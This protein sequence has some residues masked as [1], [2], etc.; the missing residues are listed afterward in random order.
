MFETEPPSFKKKHDAKP[1]PERI[2]HVKHQGKDH[3][4]VAIRYALGLDTVVIIG[5]FDG[6]FIDGGHDLGG[7]ELFLA[8]QS[9]TQTSV[10]LRLKPLVCR[11]ELRSSYPYLSDTV[12]PLL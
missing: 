4:P 1:I 9:I 5:G 2:E 11:V 7:L 10:G 3:N 6:L 12:V 8:E